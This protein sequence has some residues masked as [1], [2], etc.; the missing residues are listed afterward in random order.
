[1]EWN[2]KVDKKNFFFQRVFE[3]TASKDA[4]G[5]KKA[6]CGEKK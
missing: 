5:E 3:L 2:S 1:M 4:G 6:F